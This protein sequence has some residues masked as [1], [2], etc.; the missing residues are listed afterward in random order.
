MYIYKFSFLD[1]ILQAALQ[2]HNCIR[3]VHLHG[4]MLMSRICRLINGVPETEECMT[5]E[6]SVTC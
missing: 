6:S 3:G 4:N 5:K 1:L 2:G